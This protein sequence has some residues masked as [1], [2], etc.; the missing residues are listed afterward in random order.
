MVKCFKLL[1]LIILI[2][3]VGL[4]FVIMMGWKMVMFLYSSGLVFVI[5]ILFGKGMVYD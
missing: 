3:F 5:F 2:W 1:I 4:I